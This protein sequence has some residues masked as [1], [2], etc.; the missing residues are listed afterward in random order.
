MIVAGFG[1]SSRASAEDFG[2]ALDA[3]L[4]RAG[5]RECD[6]TCMATLDDKATPDFM[7]FAESRKLAVI[8]VDHQSA[9]GIK[10]ETISAKSLKEKN[11]ASVAESTALAALSA[12]DGGLVARLIVPRMVVGPVTCAI[13]SNETA[14]EPAP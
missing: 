7:S 4:V 14:V 8:A 6:V 12:A 11:L 5:I 1:S 3:A 13:A 2:A 9:S 10:T